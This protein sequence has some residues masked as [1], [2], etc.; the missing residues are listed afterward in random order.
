MDIERNIRTLINDQK[1]VDKSI[2]R[3]KKKFIQEIKSGLGKQ[4]LEDISKEKEKEI[5]EEPQTKGL[6]RT[7]KKWISNLLGK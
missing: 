1:R 4:I 3:N 7:M 5:K 6:F 2:E